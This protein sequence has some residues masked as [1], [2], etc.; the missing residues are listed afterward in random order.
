MCDLNHRLA[1]AERIPSHSKMKK[2]RKGEKFLK[3]YPQAYKNHVNTHEI[4]KKLTPVKTK[5]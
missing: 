5:A 4:R 3:R 1:P 2:G